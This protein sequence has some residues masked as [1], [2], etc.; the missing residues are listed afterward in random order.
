MATRNRDISWWEEEPPPALRA[1]V[2][3]RWAVGA[4]AGG[5]HRIL[6]DG[7]MDLLHS[8]ARPAVIAGPDTEAFPVPRTAGTTTVGLRL[9]PGAAAA[10]L[11]LPASD[12][13]DRRVS[14]VESWGDTALRLEET[15][16]A[17]RSPGQRLHALEAAVLERLPEAGPP[18]R[19]VA[20]AAARLRFRPATGVSEL[21]AALGL[22]ERHLRRRFHTAVGYG[23]KL[24]ARVARFQRL[25][26]L[27][28]RRPPARGELAELALEAGYADQ[29][30]MTAECAR[31]AALPP[32]RLLR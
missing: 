32:A 18:D 30:H 20:A 7:W 9:Q 10:L 19:T 29:A 6:P 11:G 16:A 12:L 17:A 15:L 1:F 22:S 2:A 14:L 5:E 31:L 26:V 23:P 8:E 13:R 3:R 25:L 24:F 28:E 4:L 27:A 21:G